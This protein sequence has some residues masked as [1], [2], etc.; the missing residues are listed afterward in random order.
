[1]LKPL[2]FALLIA[3]IAGSAQAGFP[4]SLTG[5]DLA[6]GQPVKLEIAA[7]PRATVIA[8][9]S[10]ACPCSSSHETSLEAL[11]TQY[12]SQGFR[13]IGIH[14][15]QD[16]SAASTTAH[17][18][19][20]PVKFPIIGDESAKLADSV[21]AFKTPHVFVISPKGEI[22][23][24]GGVDDSHEASAAKKHFLADAIAA[25]AA[26][27]RPEIPEARTLGCLISR[28]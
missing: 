17:F 9:L 8:F 1:M 24:Q 3:F 13:F 14:S 25:I 27:K 2:K 16:E 11:R 10:A 5:T 20:S 12:E 18:K 22:L 15:N 21:A 28:H 26:G 19:N 23:Y 6:S 4:P 7:T